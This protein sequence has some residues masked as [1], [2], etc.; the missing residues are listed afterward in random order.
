MK[1]GDSSYLLENIAR[2]MG[3]SNNIS[4]N[5]TPPEKTSLEKGTLFFPAFQDWT[6][7]G[8]EWQ[9]RYGPIPGFKKLWKMGV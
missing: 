3:E 1:L 6:A 7:F 8:D 9:R 5:K 2:F 4:I